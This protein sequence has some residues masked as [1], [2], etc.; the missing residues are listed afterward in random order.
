MS[1]KTLLIGG[2]VLVAAWYFFIRKKTTTAST[3][4]YQPGAPTKAGTT[5]TAIYKG[6]TYP[7]GL[8]EGDFVKGP[9]YPEVYLL[10]GGQKLATTRDW[11]LQ[12]FGDDYSNVKI[13]E[14]YKLIDVPTGATLSL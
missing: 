12:Y 2:A 10:K 4:T 5:Y 14:Q 8:N 6:A 1:K 7:V 11:W 3:T 9:I 13:V